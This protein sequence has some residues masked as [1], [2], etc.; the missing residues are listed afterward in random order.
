VVGDCIE[1]VIRNLYKPLPWDA[2]GSR[3][4]LKHFLTKNMTPEIHRAHAALTELNLQV[5]LVF[6]QSAY[7]GSGAYGHVFRVKNNANQKLALKVVRSDE[8]S[9]GTEYFTLQKALKDCAPV[10]KVLDITT[11]GYAYTMTPVGKSLPKTVE[12]C[13]QL[14]ATLSEL[15]KCGW[16][17]GDARYPN[18]IETTE[19]KILWIDF[20]GAGHFETNTNALIVDKIKLALSFLGKLQDEDHSALEEKIRNGHGNDDDVYSQSS[21]L[22]VEIGGRMDVWE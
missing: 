8:I 7:L 10:V 16:Y 1:S 18:A 11:S 20:L 17:H 5:D 15:H 6:D 14:F 21:S 3:R 4:I 22:V 9:S 13:R 19:R 2:P 12:T